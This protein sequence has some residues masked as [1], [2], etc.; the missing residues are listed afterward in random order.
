MSE[1][2]WADTD[3]GGQIPFVPE[4]CTERYPLR[5]GSWPK[6]HLYH[7]RTPDSEL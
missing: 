5:V 6:V 7:H 2:V 3:D 1:T 4:L